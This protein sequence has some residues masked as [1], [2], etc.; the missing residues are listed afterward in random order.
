MLASQILLLLLTL[1]VPGSNP[2][3]K[4][5]CSELPYRCIGIGANIIVTVKQP[6]KTPGDI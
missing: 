3:P 4:E 2:P 5:V 1:F 6:F